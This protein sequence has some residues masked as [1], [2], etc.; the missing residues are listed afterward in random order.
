MSI[1]AIVYASASFIK[2]INSY[3]AL[4]LSRI[5]SAT[6]S[7]VLFATCESWYVHEH[8]ESYDFPMEWVGVTLETASRY[9]G[10]FSAVAGVVGFIIADVFNMHAYGPSVV[11]GFCMLAAVGL[12][13]SKWRENRGSA[14]NVKVKKILTDGLKAIIKTKNVLKVCIIQ[15]LVEG[16]IYVFIFLWTPTLIRLFQER[17]ERTFDPQALEQAAEAAGADDAVVAEIQDSPGDEEM[18]IP[19]GIIFATFMLAMMIGGKVYDLFCKSSLFKKSNSEVLLYST[20]MATAAMGWLAT[21]NNK[22]A[23]TTYLAFVLFELSCGA[24]FPSMAALRNRIIPQK[25]A[26]VIGVWVRIPLN[27]LATAALIYL[28][29]ETDKENGDKELYWLCTIAM[30]LATI[31]CLF[32]NFKGNDN[33]NSESNTDGEDDERDIFIPVQKPSINVEINLNKSGEE[34]SG[35]A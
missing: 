3:F 14:K 32:S 25:E 27:S 2:C 26:P 28:H 5:L 24:Y 20:A 4:F 19:I 13:Q 31:I 11:G 23:I 18:K 33:G 15:S 10:I 16:V 21:H 30:G 8:L 12:I 35:E 7:S 22:K 6:S 1:A 9:N 29:T 17:A 34:G